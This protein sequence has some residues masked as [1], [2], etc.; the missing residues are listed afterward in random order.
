[1]VRE[2]S[3]V[4]VEVGRGDAGDVAGEALLLSDSRKPAQ[5]LAVGVK[6][7]GRLALHLAAEEVDIDEPNQV[8]LPVAVAVPS[9]AHRLVAI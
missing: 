8:S 6:G 7:V 3:Q 5:G 9:Y 4:G 2:A 1:M